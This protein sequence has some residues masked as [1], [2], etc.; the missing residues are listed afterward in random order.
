MGFGLLGLQPTCISCFQETIWR[1]IGRLSGAHS[2]LA[3]IHRMPGKRW[4]S[5]V[6]WHFS[7]W[8]WKGICSCFM[9]HNLTKSSH[10]IWATQC[11]HQSRSQSG[12]ACHGA[13]ERVLFPVE[14]W[15][16]QLMFEKLSGCRNHVRQ[17]ISPHV[18]WWEYCEQTPCWSCG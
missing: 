9:P 18:T 7:N 15:G 17:K 2:S 5:H 4:H 10:S 12:M 11:H 3:I 8:C 13:K 16:K 14:L 1:N 6:L